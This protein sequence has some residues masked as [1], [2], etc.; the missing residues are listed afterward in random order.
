MNNDN[1]LIKQKTKYI[2]Y[3]LLQ[4]NLCVKLDW[5]RVLVLWFPC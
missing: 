5:N 2:N 3:N 4:I 1:K